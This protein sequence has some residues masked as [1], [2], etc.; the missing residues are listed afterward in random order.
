MSS[1]KVCVESSPDILGGLI[2]EKKKWVT[3]LNYGKHGVLSASDVI[4]SFFYMGVKVN[5][6]ELRDILDGLVCSSDDDNKCL[7]ALD[8]LKEKIPEGPSKALAASRENHRSMYKGRISSAKHALARILVCASIIATFL[9]N[10]YFTPI[11]PGDRGEG[12]KVRRVTFILNAAWSI[13]QL[14][15]LILPCL[16]VSIYGTWTSLAVQLAASAYIVSVCL[17]LGPCLREACHFGT[18]Q[19]SLG[20]DVMR[21]REH[22]RF[23]TISTSEGHI[24]AIDL[25]RQVASSEGN[26]PMLKYLNRDSLFSHL[27]GNKHVA[28]ANTTTSATSDSFNGKDIETKYGLK[29]NLKKGNRG[30][31]YFV[32]V[33]MFVL[34]VPF[35]CLAANG[36]GSWL[37]KAEGD[38]VTVMW[39]LTFLYIS[40]MLMIGLQTF[41][42]S[43]MVKLIGDELR[44]NFNALRRFLLI[45]GALKPGDIYAKWG[46][47]G[48][49]TKCKESEIFLEFRTTN[50][51]AAVMSA[52]DWLHKFIDYKTRFHS[53]YIGSVII[54]DLLSAATFLLISLNDSPMILPQVVLLTSSLVSTSVLFSMAPYLI[55]TSKMLS[56]TM[57][58]FLL[59]KR[60]L[61]EE[62]VCR[63]EEKNTAHLKDE[64]IRSA[65]LQAKFLS[66][67]IEQKQLNPGHLKCLGVQLNNKAALHISGAIAGSLLSGIARSFS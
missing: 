64:D 47:N 66:N 67:L 24:G 25:L 19:I 3:A 63:L 49:L 6:S 32:S 53:G 15:L 36:G 41:L 46:Y 1:T 57:L 16:S 22:L 56:D 42:Y 17:Q 55:E 44:C 31:L 30:M 51:I 65:K 62:S 37:P 52:F 33:S 28:G 45:I 13:S 59:E 20:F 27:R 14:L 2:S 10:K 34:S 9:T 21:K 38:K 8:L 60:R 58:I 26:K 29:K 7:K 4:D 50:D 39:P 18:Q 35:G 23:W 5:Q 54:F 48:M 12:A 40:V 11:P 61:L 43:G